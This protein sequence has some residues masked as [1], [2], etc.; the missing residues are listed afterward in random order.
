[1]RKFIASLLPVVCLTSALL[2]L[3]SAGLVAAAEPAHSSATATPLRNGW[4]TYYENYFYTFDSCHAR[5]LRVTGNYSGNGEIPGTT[6]FFCY[7]EL[8]DQKFS[9]DLYWS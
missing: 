7:V 8:G 6:N 1:M 2:G 9:M 4:T 5:G 3:S